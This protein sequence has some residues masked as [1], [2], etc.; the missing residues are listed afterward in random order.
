MCSKCNN[1]GCSCSKEVKLRGPRGF[2][3]EAGPQGLQ[4][5]SGSTG[6]GANI[7]I[8]TEDDLTVSSNTV[9]DN[10]VYTLGRPKEFTYASITTQL[11]L[12]VDPSFVTLQY[13]QPAGYTTLNH[14]NLS[15]VSKQYKVYG[16][17]QHEALFQSNQFT[18][19][20]WVDA[21][22]IKTGGIVEK[23]VFG[24]YNL[25]SNLFWGAAA[26]ESIGTG[27]PIHNVIDDQGSTIEVRFQ[28]IQF[29][30]GKSLFSLV[31]LAPGETVSL[32]FRTKDVTPVG[33]PA[34]AWLVSGSIMVEEL[35]NTPIP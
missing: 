9:G 32:M 30:P 24:I 1:N 4:G 22:I 10:T 14:T 33:T 28:T 5:P 29:T 31:T 19:T 7:D 21:A 23:Q 15:L 25:R 2:Q 13:F 11:D 20:T 3:G 18:C 26:N 12:S 35:G 6:P 34:L 27:T 8:I 16:E 17:Y